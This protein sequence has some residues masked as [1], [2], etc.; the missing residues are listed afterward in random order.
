MTAMDSF[1][2]IL[3]ESRK[4]Q[5]P[6]PSYLCKLFVD[7]VCKGNTSK[8]SISRIHEKATGY[9]PDLSLED[10]LKL[11]LF[12]ELPQKKLSIFG[13]CSVGSVGTVSMPYS[14]LFHLEPMMRTSMQTRGQSTTLTYLIPTVLRHELDN[15]NDIVCFVMHDYP[16]EFNK[17][18]TQKEKVKVV[19]VD[20]VANMK[21]QVRDGNELNDHW[22][23]H[24][25]KVAHSV[26][27]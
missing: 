19:Y 3:L 11:K 12:R 4:Y 24:A 9:K 20:A 16:N 7:R 27:C 21:A 23:Y 2:S 1:E 13:S 15:H 22:S 5:K 14:V 8:L 18:W 25:G 10:E 26:C 6:L 17:A